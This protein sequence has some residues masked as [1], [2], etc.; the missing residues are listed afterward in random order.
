[1]AYNNDEVKANAQKFGPKK[2][3][4]FTLFVNANKQKGDKP[5]GP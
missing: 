5:K 3:N 2:P 4:G 1:M